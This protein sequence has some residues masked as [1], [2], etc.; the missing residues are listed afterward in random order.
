MTGWQFVLWILT[1]AGVMVVGV[2]ALNRG[3]ATK[4]KKTDAEEQ[5]QINEEFNHWKGYAAAL[6]AVATAFLGFVSSGVG[7][8]LGESAKICGSISAVAGVATVALLVFWQTK[9]VLFQSASK[10]PWFLLLASMAT[11]LQVFFYA[12]FVLSK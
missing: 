11:T 1:F 5:K 2:I 12:G 4:T 6:G 3:T 9:E 7:D 10:K 8:S